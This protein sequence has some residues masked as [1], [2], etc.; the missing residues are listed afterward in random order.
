MNSLTQIGS[1]VDLDAIMTDA[2]HGFLQSPQ[3]SAVIHQAMTTS[4]HILYNT[5]FI[6]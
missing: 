6:N 5:L 3:A 1:N 2:F 4:F